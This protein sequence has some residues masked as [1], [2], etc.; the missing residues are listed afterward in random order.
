M[1]TLS[2]QRCGRVTSLLFSY[3]LDIAKVV[4]KE[5]PRITAAVFRSGSIHGLLRLLSLILS[6]TDEGAS[7][8][9]HPAMIQQVGAMTRFTDGETDSE[10]LV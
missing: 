1:N 10:A 6:W 9:S 2:P 3:K 8:T 7:P 5:Q 4:S